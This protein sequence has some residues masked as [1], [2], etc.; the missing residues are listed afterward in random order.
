[1]D[2]HHG[3][4]A[5]TDLK[6]RLPRNLHRKAPMV[7]VLHPRKTKAEV[8]HEAEVHPEEKL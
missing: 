4:V 7:G 2:Q 1:M 6:A 5:A 3:W 8:H